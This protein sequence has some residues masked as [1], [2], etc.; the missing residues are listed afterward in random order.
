MF[1]I[2]LIFSEDIFYFLLLRTFH[3]QF[4]PNLPSLSDTGVVRVGEHVIR[5]R[6]AVDLGRLLYDLGRLLGPVGGDQPPVATR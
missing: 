4:M 6:L 5:D 3:G 1:I 2:N